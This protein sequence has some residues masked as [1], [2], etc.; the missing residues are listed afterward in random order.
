MTACSHIDDILAN[1][2]ERENILSVYNSIQHAFKHITFKEKLKYTMTCMECQMVNNGCSYLCLDCGYCG[3]WNGSHFKDHFKKDNHRFGINSSNNL[4]YCFDC[5]DYANNDL[6]ILSATTGEYYDQVIKDTTVPDL[7]RLDGLHG[8]V[9]M[10][11]TC[12]LSSILQCLIHNSLFV[13]LSM[14]ALHQKNCLVN[15][16]LQCMSCSINFLIAETYGSN[17]MTPN[18]G[19]AKILNCSWKVKKSLAGY[20]QQDAHEFLQFLLNQMHNDYKIN[21]PSHE[22]DN[23]KKE[24][25]NPD[26]QLHLCNCI[27]HSIFQGSMKSVISC[28]ECNTQSQTTIDPFMD[29]SLVIKGKKTLYECLENFHRIEKLHDFNY[30]CKNC[31]TSQDAN[32]QLSI[33]KLA[34]ILVIQLKRFEHLINSTSVKLNDYIQFPIHLNM[35]KFCTK[36]ENSKEEDIPDI[37]YEL[38]GIVTHMG[39]VN[40]GHY[41]TYS[42]TTNGQWFQF[43]DSMVTVVSEEQMLKEQAYLLFYTVKQLN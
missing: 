21:E 26:Q 15:D 37:I 43:N 42:K 4:V 22:I 1:P 19:L 27:P 41:I 28:V 12:F 18:E 16:P 32:R 5:D 34:P 3:C 9:N 40:E 31:N 10:G 8:L 17:K 7:K 35:K 20:S 11:S 24:D 25:N 14:Q 38:S 36:D 29:L 23:M 2:S 13:T 6:L 33:L 30:Q 39:T